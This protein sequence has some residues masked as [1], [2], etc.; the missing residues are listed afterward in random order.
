MLF[1]FLSPGAVTER[2]LETNHRDEDKID[3]KPL[4]CKKP[5]II[6]KKWHERILVVVF[7]FF[8]MGEERGGGEVAALAKA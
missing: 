8:I 7:F 4:A 5:M 2:R 3:H 1:F 6:I